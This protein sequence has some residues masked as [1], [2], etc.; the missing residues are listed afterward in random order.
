MTVSLGQLGKD[1][2]T[3][4]GNVLVKALSVPIEMPAGCC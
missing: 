3:A 1:G 2:R 4:L